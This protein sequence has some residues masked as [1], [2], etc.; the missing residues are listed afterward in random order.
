MNREQLS[1]AVAEAVRRTPSSIRRLA[2][3]VGVSHVML[4]QVRDGERPAP[5][6][7]AERIATIMEGW[8]EE[9]ADLAHG[10]REALDAEPPSEED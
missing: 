6:A 4:L 9:L 8:G 3:E 10:I 7:L 1:N 2:R 5:P